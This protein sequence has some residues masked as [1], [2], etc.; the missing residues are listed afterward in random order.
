[1]LRSLLDT[2]ADYI[3]PMT[4]EQSQC[5]LE[6]LAAEKQGSTPFTRCGLYPASLKSTLDVLY[7][8]AVQW[9]GIK[10]S[11]SLAIFIA[12]ISRD[13]PCAIII[14][15][16]TLV[17]IYDRLGGR[18]L[19]LSDLARFFQFGFPT[20]EGI[21]VMVDRQKDGGQDRLDEQEH[22]TN[23]VFKFPSLALGNVNVV[24]EA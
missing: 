24:E 13:I 21:R 8:R 15:A 14:W 12:T 17:N 9:G 6:Y 20:R 18:M 2:P 11:R 10:I 19:L 5:F 3:Q 16:F 22:W 1:M 4:P 7:E 23:Q